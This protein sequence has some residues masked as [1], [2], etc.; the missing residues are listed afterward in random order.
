MVQDGQLFSFDLEGVS[1]VPMYIIQL[2]F[3]TK[4]YH[5][6]SPNT[7]E[8]PIMDT[9]KSGQPPYNGQT[10]CPLPTTACTPYISTSEIRTTL[11]SEKL[12][13]L[14]SRMVI[15]RTKLPPLT[16]NGR[17]APAEMQKIV[18]TKLQYIKASPCKNMDAIS[19]SD[20]ILRTYSRGRSWGR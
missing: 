11:T 14:T 19:R 5:Y 3:I 17:L 9:P 20:S 7:V 16:D 6:C 2:G 15:P 13:N 1:S 4:P 12:K 10:T 8:P 18:H